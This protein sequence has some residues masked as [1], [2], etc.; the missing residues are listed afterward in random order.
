ME[1]GGREKGVV[2]IAL[3]VDGVERGAGFGC[4]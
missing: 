4:N 1:D 3:V 2:L